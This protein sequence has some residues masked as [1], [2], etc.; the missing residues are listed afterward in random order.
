MRAALGVD[1]GTL[2]A[3]ALVVDMAT[4]R[5]LGTGA[6]D[7]AHGVL[8]RQ[9]PSGRALPPDW[10]LS[11]PE[12]YWQS[13]IAAVHEAVE[14]AGIPPEQIAA[15]GVDTTSSTAF[16]ADGRGVPLCEQA[17]FRDNPWA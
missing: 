5:E 9:L 15:I 3:R 7:Y 8:E 16:P 1:F 17:R 4:G 6:C 14:S 11:W 10:A 2:S 13:L 12:D